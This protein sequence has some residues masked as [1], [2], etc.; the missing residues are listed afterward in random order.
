VN[1]PALKGGVF[2][3]MPPRTLQGKAGLFFRTEKSVP[4]NRGSRQGEREQ[5]VCPHLLWFYYAVRLPAI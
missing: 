2:P 5:A 4:R 3:L 1:Y